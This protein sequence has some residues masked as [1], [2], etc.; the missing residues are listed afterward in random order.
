MPEPSHNTLFFREPNHLAQTK[1]QNRVSQLASRRIEKCQ[2]RHGSGRHIFLDGGHCC[3]RVIEREDSPGQILKPAPLAAVHI[4]LLLF[5]PDPTITQSRAR[6]D[7]K[8]TL[9]VKIHDV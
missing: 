8:A 2:A 4:E 6:R 1:R 9:D 5:L 3:K 7:R